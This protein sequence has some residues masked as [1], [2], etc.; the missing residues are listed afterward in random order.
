M[1]VD[2]SHVPQQFR[3]FDLSSHLLISICCYVVRG[4]VAP[5]CIL[6]S[7][8]CSIIHDL[9]SLFVRGDRA[10]PTYTMTPHDACPS[11]RTP[12]ALTQRTCMHWI[13]CMRYIVI[14]YLHMLIAYLRA[15]VHSS[16]ERVHPYIN[17]HASTNHPSTPTKAA[18]SPT[19]KAFNYI[20]SPLKSFT[21][22]CHSCQSGMWLQY[23]CEHTHAQARPTTTC[24]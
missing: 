21:N 11:V 22:A 5:S 10:A 13:A 24:F 2:W 9:L 17:I 19:F 8:S 20:W 4:Y 16:L 15:C 3:R 23:T 12:P 14:Y 18:P 7:I 1:Y 6:H